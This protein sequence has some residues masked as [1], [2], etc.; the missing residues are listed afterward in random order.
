[1]DHSTNDMNT[2]TSQT[3]NGAIAGAS[4]LLPAGQVSSGVRAREGNQQ[5]I[6]TARH[7][8]H[9]GSDFSVKG[10]GIALYGLWNQ[11]LLLP[12]DGPQSSPEVWERHHRLGIWYAT[13]LA[14]QSAGQENSQPWLAATE[15][16]DACNVLLHR[17]DTLEAV[18]K[19]NTPAGTTP[20]CIAYRI[21]CIQ[22]LKTQK[23]HLYRLRP[24]RRGKE[25]K[26]AEFDVQE[27]FVEELQ[28]Q[29][30]LVGEDP[31]TGWAAN[32]FTHYDR[33]SQRKGW[34]VVTPQRS[35]VAGVGTIEARTLA[36]L[37]QTRDI[38]RT[39]KQ[40]G[41]IAER[42]EDVL[43]RIAIWNGTQD[44]AETVSH[45]EDLV[46]SGKKSIDGQVLLNIA[47]ASLGILLTLSPSLH[48]IT[49]QVAGSF[50]IILVASLLFWLRARSG[51][52]LWLALGLLLMAAAFL[53]ASAPLWFYPL[54]HFL[55]GLH[56]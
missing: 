32:R 2:E 31:Q 29:F 38:D 42:Y 54:L 17:L 55:S 33:N 7:F 6:S 35:L 23:L 9:P 16:L 47:L 15:V 40:E 27:A 20:A 24:L 56:L 36:S 14:W 51:H 53:L 19:R 43:G 46:E 39:G 34:I 21:L 50:C 48:L 4:S 18:N 41:I 49:W 26:Q 28:R 1:M 12:E 30:G 22:E 44:I 25:I 3:K 11:A 13:H 8:L 5:P 37:I 10:R 52:A 45:L